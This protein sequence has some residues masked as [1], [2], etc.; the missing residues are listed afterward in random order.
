MSNVFL[1]G[2]PNANSAPNMTIVEIEMIS[3][4]LYRPMVLP[5]IMTP[6]NPAQIPKFP[7]SVIKSVSCNVVVGVVKNTATWVPQTMLTQ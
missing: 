2:V 5:K 7:G 3:C 6:R 4:H 1:S